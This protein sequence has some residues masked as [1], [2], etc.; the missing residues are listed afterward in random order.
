MRV[1]FVMPYC[2]VSNMQQWRN[3]NNWVLQITS[4]FR[5]WKETEKLC[6]CRPVATEVI[7]T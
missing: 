1:V 6:F 3:S 2:V 5:K 7:K 4:V